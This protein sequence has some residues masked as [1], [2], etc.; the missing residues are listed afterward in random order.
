MSANYEL[1]MATEMQYD[2]ITSAILRTKRPFFF[3]AHQQDC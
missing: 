3:V 2:K 1:D